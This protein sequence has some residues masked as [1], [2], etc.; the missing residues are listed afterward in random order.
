MLLSFKFC[1]TYTNLDRLNG[2]DEY[3]VVLR[4]VSCYKGEIEG[5]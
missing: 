1:I 5:L 2:D 3:K 4:S